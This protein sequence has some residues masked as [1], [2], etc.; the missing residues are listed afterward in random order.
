MNTSTT[1]SRDRFIHSVDVLLRATERQ[2]RTGSLAAASTTVVAAGV[3]CLIVDKPGRRR[4]GFGQEY[5]E[6]RVRVLFP[7]PIKIDAKHTLRFVDV[8]GTTRHVV[9][10][11]FRDDTNQGLIFVAECQEEP[12]T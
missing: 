12:A 6:K 11:S 1:P 10:D 3:P 8:Q 9:V 7:D 2:D 4:T 5:Q